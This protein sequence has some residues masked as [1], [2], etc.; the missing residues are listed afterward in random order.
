MRLS[1]D[2]ERRKINR[3][4]A[5]NYVMTTLRTVAIVIIAL[6]SGA[7]EAADVLQLSDDSTIIV[8]ADESWEEA[9]QDIIHFRGDFELRTPRWSV[10]SDH[11]TVYGKVDDPKRIVADGSPVQFVFQNSGADDISITEGEGQHLEYDSEAGLLSLSGGAKLTSGR[12]VMKS[13]KIQYDVKRERLEAGGP[14]GVH[15]TVVPDSSGT[16]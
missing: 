12:R 8:S 9:E 11:A 5:N 7:S 2:F 1:V 15:V 10:M 13:S 14:E 4:A 16:F 3:C 6:I